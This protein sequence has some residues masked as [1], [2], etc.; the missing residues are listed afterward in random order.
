M[1]LI[2]ALLALFCTL[3]ALEPAHARAQ[4]S[5]QAPHTIALR[6]HLLP[7]QRLVRG[8]ARMAFRNTSDVPLGKLV[9]HLYMNAFRD[10]KSVF[11]R[12]SRGMLR[13][14]TAGSAGSITLRT[15]RIDGKD[16]LARRRDQLE[17]HDRTQLE[18]DLSE[19]LAPGD[20]IQIDTEF[21]TKLPDLFA[22]AG[23]S[24]D[25]FAV[26]QWF[27]K[28]AKLEPDGRFA[29]FPYHAL[30][31]FYADFADYSLEIKA[32]TN[33]VV[34]ASGTLTEERSTATET[35][36]RF[37]ARNVHDVAFV[38]SPSLKV[39]SER[40]GDVRVTYLWP[41]GYDL[42][43][44]TVE[45]TVRAGLSHFGAKFG[46][47]PYPDLTVVLPPRGAEGAAGMEYPTFFFTAGGWMAPPPWLTGG[48]H[49]FVTAHELAH[50][51]F[52][53]MLA[54]NEVRWSVLD[55]GLTEWA[56]I[57]LLRAM[58]GDARSLTSFGPVSRF[59]AERLFTFAHARPSV[60]ARW[61]VNAY[62]QGEYGRTIYTRSAIVLETIRR[63][64]GKQ[65]FERALSF[66]A[67]SQRFRHPT[68]RELAAAFDE[69]Y[70]P[71]FAASVLVPLFLDAQTSAVHLA[72]ARCERRGNGFVSHVR[73]RRS[74]AVALPTWVALYDR[75]GRELTRRRFG[76]A[77][78]N[79]DLQIETQS[80]VARVVIDPDRALLVDANVRDQIA[81][82]D[83]PAH[84]GATTYLITLLQAVLAWVGP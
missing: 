63:V 69:I 35:I 6:A 49:A 21:D 59:E 25:F 2:A 72:E 50:Q 4:P 33:M 44:A 73:A 31:E 17:P 71:G 65:R 58:H 20:F 3:A 57:D 62:T 76:A 36:R 40:I 78:E 51:W 9:M 19:P 34:G 27:P 10:R 55:E 83:E 64:Y 81:T 26:A 24:D 75:E 1:G 18:V 30:G 15:L 66:Y 11:M 54:S 77:Q 60:P 41:D 53:G 43:M 68:P 14:Q 46:A 37:V 29:S 61:P 70:G 79:L 48:S 80:A 32:P 82:L 12:D 42:A 56:A 28:P 23:V 7:G 47:Y 39:R 13:E 16:A 5:P 74:G 8:H 84:I 22:R 45:R 38:A 67:R 52:Q